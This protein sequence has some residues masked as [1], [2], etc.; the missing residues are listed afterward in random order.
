MLL[1]NYLLRNPDVLFYFHKKQQDFFIIVY[2]IMSPW[3]RLERYFLFFNE[4]NDHD[5]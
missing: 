1:Q 3:V 4:K 5:G 2:I